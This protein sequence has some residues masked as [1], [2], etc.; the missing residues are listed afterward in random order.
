MNRIHTYFEVVPEMND[1]NELKLI[2]L[3]E[4]SWAKFGF[5]TLVLN[6]SHARQHPYW[7]E[8]SKAVENLP[9][10]NPKGYERACWVRHL[11]MAQVGGGMISDYDCIPRSPKFPS[12]DLSH[13]TLWEFICP[14]LISA[15][16]ERF[17]WLCR[18]FASYKPDDDDKSIHGVHT[19][20]QNVIRRILGPMND[21]NC[22]IKVK[23]E[24]KLYGSPGWE[25][26]ALVHFSNGSMGPAGKMPKYKYIPELINS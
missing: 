9:T 24:V 20:D 17:E 6:E 11:A 19:S 5:E 1:E 21:D 18:Q 8:Y 14:S 7:D 10:I 26:S 16:S 2:E 23:A 22:P 25:T 15:S 4:K 13:I 3:W 12:I